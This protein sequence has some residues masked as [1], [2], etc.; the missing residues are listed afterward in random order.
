ME[1]APETKAPRTTSLRMEED[2]VVMKQ[3]AKEMLG[4]EK[5]KAG[6]MQMDSSGTASSSGQKR[7]SDV[8]LEELERTIG[9]VMVT[10]DLREAEETN[11]EQVTEAGGE[12]HARDDVN[13]VAIPIRLVDEARSKETKYP[14]GK[15]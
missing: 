12:R 7:A 14:N 8:P 4:L 11:I 2:D 9:N 6:K 13:N 10:M 5:L 1:D 3:V 15:A